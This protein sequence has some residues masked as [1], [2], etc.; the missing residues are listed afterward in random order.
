VA[1]YPVR[2]V[3]G[4]RPARATGP[5]ATPHSAGSLA[6]TWL[7]DGAQ[8]RPRSTP[9]SSARD[10]G[11]LHGREGVGLAAVAVQ[12]D[13]EQLPGAL[14]ERVGRRRVPR[15]S[16]RASGGATGPRGGRPRGR[17]AP[18]ARSSAQLPRA[19]ADGDS[20]RSRRGGWWGGSAAYGS[21]R[22]RARACSSCSARPRQGRRRPRR[23]PR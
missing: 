10:R 4:A 23:A 15:S 18:R 14:E 9:S 2:P 22:H 16:A 20:G 17:R 11:A 5:A 1:S 13:D 21:P 3:Y 12:R 7:L 6:R 8:T 19:S